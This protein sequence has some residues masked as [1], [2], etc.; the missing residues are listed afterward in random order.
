MIRKIARKTKNLILNPVRFKNLMLKPSRWLLAQTAFVV[1][2]LFRLAPADTSINFMGW[3]SRHVGPLLPRSKIGMINLRGAF[4]EKSEA[5]L[6]QILRLSWDNLG[7]M[8]A[9]YIF[10]D[11]LMD[12]NV[13]DLSKGRVEYSNGEIFQRLRDDEKPA[14]IF[15]A[16]LGNWELL[17]VCAGRFGLNVQALFRAPN[18]P[19]IAKKLADARGQVMEGL[20]PSGSGAAYRLSQCL[21]DGDHVGL[22]VDQKFYSGVMVPFFGRDVSTNPL[23]A[24]LLRAHECP[25]HGARTIRLPN[26]RFRLEI[27]EE[28]KVPRDENGDVDIQ[29][30]MA[31][32]TSVV[33]EWVR[34]YPEQ[35]LWVHKRWPL[36]LK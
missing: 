7:R 34:E 2:G 29:R 9:E 19:Y 5:E 6:R 23:L 20:V 33:E 27:T 36:P 25:L 22:L 21:S 28:I 11:R 17:P 3:A 24:K 10:L 26:G 13:E 31:K 30:T 35:W 8:V 14:L 16:H 1:M 4:P 32:V 18:N 15:A 12:I